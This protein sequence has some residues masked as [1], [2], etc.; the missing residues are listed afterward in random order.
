MSNDTKELTA[1]RE[2]DALVAH[3]VFGAFGFENIDVING[4]ANELFAVL[5]GNRA[6]NRVPYFSTDIAAAWDVVEK[7]REISPPRFQNLQLIVYA[8]N[9]TYAT[10]DA[11]AFSDY[12]SATWTEANGE[13]ATPLAICLAALKASA[14]FSEIPGET[15]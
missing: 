12:D 14:V 15:K 10:F 8:Y 3:E 5:P 6:V 2:L 7:V 4:P 9:R 1:G 11:E 13:H